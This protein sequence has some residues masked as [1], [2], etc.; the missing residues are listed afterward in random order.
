MAFETTKKGDSYKKP[1]NKDQ[2]DNNKK[3]TVM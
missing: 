2:V 3:T 1:N